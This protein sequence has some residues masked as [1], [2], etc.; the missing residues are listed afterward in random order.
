[1]TTTATAPT[2]LIASTSGD[3]MSVAVKE[4]TPGLRKDVQVGYKD[5]HDIK[6]EIRFRSKTS[7]THSFFSFL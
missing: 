3:P 5:H 7:L 6:S 1:M 4:V 2:T